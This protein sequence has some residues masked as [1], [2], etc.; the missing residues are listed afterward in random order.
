[1]TGAGTTMPHPAQPRRKRD[2]R[3]RLRQR[4]PPSLFGFLDPGGQAIAEPLLGTCKVPE[5]FVIN[6]R[7]A[8]VEK[9]LGAFPW[10][11]AEIAAILGHIRETG[12]VPA[13]GT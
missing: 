2:P 9:S 5:T 11:E 8:V 4:A 6:R 3:R 12:R 7:G 1:M 10:A 13:Q